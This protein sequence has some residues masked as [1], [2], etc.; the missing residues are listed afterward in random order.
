MARAALRAILLAAA[1]LAA[2]AARAEDQAA[3]PDAAAEQRRALESARANL[4]ETQKRREQLAAELEALKGERAK[5]QSG[6]ASAVA[7]IREKEPAID[8]RSRRIGELAES[9]RQLKASLLSRREVLA[10]VIAALQR[11]GRQPPPA[12][13]VRPN[14]ALEALRSAILLGA[15]VPDMRAEAEALGS[16]LREMARLKEMLTGER[17]ALTREVGD[18]AAERERLAALMDERQRQ[19]NER[20]ADLKAESERSMEVAKSVGDL[21]ALIGKMEADQARAA[22]EAAKAAAKAEADRLAA[23]K[24]VEQPK[25]ASLGDAARLSP[26][27][28]FEKARGLLPLPVSG[29]TMLAFGQTDPTGSPA[30]GVSIATSSG[31]P[32]TAPSDGWVVYAGPFRTYGRLLILNAGGGYHVLLAGMERITVG[33]NQFVLAGEPVGTMRGAASG[34]GQ[35][36]A[37]SS[38]RPVLYVEFRKDRGSIDPSPWWAGSPGEKVG[39]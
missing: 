32:V 16:D 29:K 33:L 24:S 15:V 20:A 28:P 35:P 37:A 14:D 27:M 31:A 2:G 34:P 7:S 11:M 9:E 18:L 26:A 17:D 21:E 22:A 38:E 12:L 13:L 6:L 1:L 23:E 25:P 30:R 4:E 5:L 10:E 36:A 8:G 39:G 19:A 3:P